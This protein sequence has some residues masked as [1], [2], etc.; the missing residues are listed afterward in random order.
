LTFGADR[1][2]ALLVR[3]TMSTS[4]PGPEF[5][6]DRDTMPPLN[7]KVLLFNTDM[8]EWQIARLEEREGTRWWVLD[9]HIFHGVDSQKFPRWL[10]LPEKT[11]GKPTSSAPGQG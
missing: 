3:P 10:P 1:L 6:L 4:G 7:T 9:P 5:T 2:Y 11:D 8:N